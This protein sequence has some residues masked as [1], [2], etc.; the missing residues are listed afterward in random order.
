MI[1]LLRDHLNYWRGHCHNF[2]TYGI[3]RGT[4]AQRDTAAKY[5]TIEEWNRY[6]AAYSDITAMWEKVLAEIDIVLSGVPFWEPVLMERLEV[7]GGSL[8]I[9]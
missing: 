3:T 8:Y 7:D 6:V 4:L 9:M 1:K 5:P 2:Q